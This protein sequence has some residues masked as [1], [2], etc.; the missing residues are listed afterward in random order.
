MA[1]TR[2]NDFHAAPGR[3]A[4][5]RAFLQSIISTITSAAGCIS[6]DLLVDHGDPTHIVIVERWVDI[7]A[8]QAAATLIPP[9]QLAQVQPLLAAPP[10]GVYYDPA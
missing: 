5:L 9:S 3:D 1:I 2:I 7:P 4:D 8:H 10:R 6:V